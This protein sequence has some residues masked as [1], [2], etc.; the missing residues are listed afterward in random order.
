M[1]I[2]SNE[3]KD[4]K[5]KEPNGDVGIGCILVVLMLV[6]IKFP[7]ILILVAI[8]IMGYIELNKQNINNFKNEIYELENSNKDLIQKL[9][10]FEFSS[11]EIKCLDLKK[12]I[13]VLE[14]KKIK[15]NED[16]ALLE[17]LGFI[18][19]FGFYETK[20]GLETSEEYKDKLF[21][22][23]DRQKDMVK[24]K[25]ATNHN[26]EWTIDNDKKKGKEFILDTIKLSLK[27]FNNE[28]D[29]II[30]KVK[31]SNLDA[32]EKRIRKVFDDINALTDM[33]KV[34]IKEEYLNLKIEELYLKYEYECKKQEE[35]I[36]QQEEKER[37]KEEAKVRKEIENARKKV[38]KEE[39]HFVNA[40]SDLKTKVDSANDKEKEKL[41]IKLA[42][43][44]QKLNSIEESKKDIIKREM[45]NKAGYVYIISNI[46]SFGENVYKIGMTRRLEPMERIKELGGASVPFTFDVHAMVFTED[47]P[48]LESK[49][50]EIFRDKEVN[51]V[52]HRKEFFKVDLSEIERVIKE[53][54]DKPVDFIKIADAEEYRKSLLLNND[55]N[56]VK[57]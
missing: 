46:G 37:L 16:V 57:C 4:K 26:L 15:L 49:L 9:K 3:P 22:I 40:I 1:N 44:E 51:K 27:A 14:D 47:A 10:E 53:E 29:N 19:S 33:Q 38:E 28:C 20:Y 36:K 43:L 34:S 48:K 24:S 50:H 25:T 55:L 32:S 42:E 13:N 52:N 18:Q 21:I 8:I 12:E 17:E 45:N 23:R 31:Y 30:T 35:K 41:L 6:S 5:P 54:F 2:K 7:I 39:Q 56:T 11:D